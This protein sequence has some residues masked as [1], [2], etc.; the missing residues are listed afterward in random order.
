MNAI[1][2][3]LIFIFLW[4][5]GSLNFDKLI[6]REY[7]FHND[8]WIRDG[9]P[10][11]MFFK[12]PGSSTISFWKKGFTP[13]VGIPEWAKDDEVAVLLFKWYFFW[14][15]AVLIYAIAFIPLLIITNFIF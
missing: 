6:S 2:L 12:P 1:I 15:K 4:L 9:R 5:V 7:Q 13:W 8:A 11:G 3:I 10:R 14:K